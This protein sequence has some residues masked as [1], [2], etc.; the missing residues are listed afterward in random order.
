MRGKLQ[1]A[2]LAMITL[3]S[4]LTLTMMFS[5]SLAS[6]A[7]DADKSKVPM[8][9]KAEPYLD[10]GEIKGFRITRIREDSIYDKA[11]LLDNDIIKSINGNALKGA[12]SAVALLRTLKS[13]EAVTLKILRGSAE[14]ELT[15]EPQKV[16]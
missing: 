5:C 4:A 11:G 9:T 15:L 10:N 8:D 12:A 1:T 7:E 6:F 3:H 2:R 16:Q 13:N 14:T